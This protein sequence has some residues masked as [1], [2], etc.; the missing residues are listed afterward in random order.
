MCSDE[1]LPAK[2]ANGSEGTSSHKYGSNYRKHLK[3]ITEVDSIVEDLKT[4]HDESRK[5]LP[6]QIRLWDHMLEMGKHDSYNSRPA[7]PFFL[8]GQNQNV[9]KK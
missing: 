2:R 7:K 6:E 5:Y 9:S 3:K 8:S 4:L 1:E